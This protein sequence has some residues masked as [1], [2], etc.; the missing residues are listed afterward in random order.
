MILIHYIGVV[1]LIGKVAQYRAAVQIR[2]DKKCRLL[3]V[4]WKAAC[5]LMASV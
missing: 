5:T 3:F 4:C 2:R 1:A